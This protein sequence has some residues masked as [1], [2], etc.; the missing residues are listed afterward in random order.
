MGK[1]TNRPTRLS[2]PRLYPSWIGV[3]LFWLVG[4]LPW[5]FLLATGRGLGHLAWRLAKRRSHIARTN[6]RLCFPELTPEEQENLARRSVISTGEAILEMAGS[7]SNHRIDLDKRLVIK[8][9]EHIEQAR[10]EGKGVLLLGMHFNSIDVGSRLLGYLMDFYAVY[11]PND[12]RVIDRLINQGR[13]N[14]LKGNVPRSDIRQMIRLL[15][16]GEVL[17]YAPDQDYG[18]AH[19]VFVPFFGIPAATITA[20]SRIARMGKARVIPTAHYRLPGGR[21]QIEFGPPLENFPSGDDEADTARINQTIEHYVR[22]HPEQY[23]WVHKRFK[24]QPDGKSFY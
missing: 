6:I 10:A 14:Y 3:G 2:D 20:T 16:N 7:F 23:L 21:Y 12:N 5:N 9:M 1:R 8:G 19:A 15:R 17:W 18:I 4:Q 22:K 11:R 24:H 13:G